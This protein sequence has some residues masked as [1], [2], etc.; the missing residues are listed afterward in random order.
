M[1]NV[2]TMVQYSLDNIARKA[3]LKT[4]CGVDRGMNFTKTK[5]SLFLLPF[6]KPHH[7]AHPN[8]ISTNASLKTFSLPNLDFQLPIRVDAN[9]R[10]VHFQ[11]GENFLGVV[12]NRQLTNVKPLSKS[13]YLETFMNFQYMYASTRSSSAKGPSKTWFLVFVF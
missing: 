6:L 8:S 5:Q 12:I 7:R 2:I 3:S 4:R 11:S 9:R 10:I 13:P 1:S